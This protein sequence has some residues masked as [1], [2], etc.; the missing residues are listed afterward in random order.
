MPRPKSNKPKKDFMGCYKHY[1][2]EVDGYGS[3]S[4]WQKSWEA[5][6]GHVEATHFLGSSNPLSILGL[7]VL[8]ATLEELKRIYRKVILSHQEGMRQKSSQEAQEL[9]KQIIASYSLLSENFT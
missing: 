4:E 1:N 8:P 6:M 3:V 9:A 2:P 5:K 7:T